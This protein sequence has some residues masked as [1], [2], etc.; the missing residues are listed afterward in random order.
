MSQMKRRRT[1]LVAA[2]G[3]LLLAVGVAQPASAAT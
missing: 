2:F 1:R 3:A